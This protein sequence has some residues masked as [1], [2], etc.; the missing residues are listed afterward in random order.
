M[1]VYPLTHHQAR[2]FIFPIGPPAL[3]AFVLVAMGDAMAG[4]LVAG[5]FTVLNTL[6]LIGAHLLEG[7]RDTRTARPRD[8]RR[9][10]KRD[11]PKKDDDT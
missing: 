9:R 1:T 3:A 7:R 5:G 10:R 8:T 11:T 2:I 4:A 6:L